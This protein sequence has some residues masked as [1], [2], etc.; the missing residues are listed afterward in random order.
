MT[1]TNPF[2]W[3]LPLSDAMLADECAYVPLGLPNDERGAPANPAESIA[4]RLIMFA[5]LAFNIDVWGSKTGRAGRYWEAFGEHIEA[6]TNQPTLAAWWDSLMR[7]LPGRMLR[8]TAL[9]HEKNMLIRP[10]NLPGTWAHDEDVLM[11][12]RMYPLELRDRT[13][14]WAK[15]RR[16]LR[17]QAVRE[18]EEHPDLDE[19]DDT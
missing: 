11:V 12:I 7:D 16:E 5:H 13:R 1:W 9:T 17:S 6:A 2:G 18:A 3:H 8:S 14:S 10:R 15:H 4:E 19:G